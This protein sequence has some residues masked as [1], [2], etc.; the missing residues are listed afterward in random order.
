M[1]D[2]NPVKPT[3]KQQAA[4]T[5]LRIIEAATAEFVGNGYHGTSMAAIAKRAGV[6]VQ[7]VYFVFHTKAELF[8]AAQDTAVLGAEDT[9]PLE[10][11]WARSAAANSHGPAAA[12][13][14]FIAGSGPIFERAGALS[15][16]ARAAAPTDPDLRAVWESREELRV[17]GYRHFVA[18]LGSSMA[19]DVDPLVAGDIMIT[20]VSPELYLG[21]RVERGWTH[22]QTIDWMSQTVPGLMLRPRP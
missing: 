5:R 19:A 22:Q 11:K 21:F 2:V 15:Q 12:I 8:A 17:Q 16:V 7:T 13:R 3:R 20:M 10:Q 9:P 14:A 4:V 18:T 6:A 1:A